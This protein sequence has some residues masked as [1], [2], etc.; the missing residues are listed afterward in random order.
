MVKRSEAVFANTVAEFLFVVAG[1]F[2][3]AF[4]A[5]L[6]GG[7]D[8]FGAGI[9][10]AAEDEGPEAAAVVG[11]VVALFFVEAGAKEIDGHLE[12]VDE[13]GFGGVAG[14]AND[15]AK[16]FE[17]LFVEAVEF[18]DEDIDGVGIAEGAVVDIYRLE[19]VFPA[20]TGAEV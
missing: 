2:G 8:D 9:D 5:F 7:S 11:D 4:A 20:R 3:V 13:F 10:V 17:V 19:P 12:F 18:G 6:E 1:G 15:D 14:F 16:G